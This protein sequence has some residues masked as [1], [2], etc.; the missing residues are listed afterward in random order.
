V[1]LKKP[2]RIDALMVVMTLCLMVYNLSE[3]HLYTALDEHEQ[4]VLNQLKKPTNRPS[5]KWIFRQF[6]GIQVLQIET[7]LDSTSLVINVKPH[8]A[9]IVTYFGQKAMTIYAVKAPA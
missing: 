3:H 2:E 6:N 5:M 9:R 4:T 1:F 8:L 7:G